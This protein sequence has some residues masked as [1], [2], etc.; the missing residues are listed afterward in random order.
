MTIDGSRYSSCF[1]S[2]IFFQRPEKYEKESRE[3][4]EWNGLS[5][6]QRLLIERSRR[7]KERIDVGRRRDGRSV[8]VVVGHMRNE[9]GEGGVHYGFV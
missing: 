9:E 6:E 7:K 8:V 2:A 5:N 4:K 3:S 1:F